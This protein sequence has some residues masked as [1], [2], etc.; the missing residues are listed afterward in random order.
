MTHTPSVLI[1][2]LNKICTERGCQ[3][4]EKFSEHLSKVKDLNQISDVT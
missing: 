4:L 3:R 2:G 1:S